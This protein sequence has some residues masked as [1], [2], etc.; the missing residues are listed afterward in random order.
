MQF[1]PSSQS[2]APKYSFKKVVS[3]HK[4]A[5]PY[6]QSYIYVR[7]LTLIAEKQAD[8]AYQDEIFINWQ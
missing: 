7:S 4:M 2:T 3:V 1:K 6:Y 8:R 5:A